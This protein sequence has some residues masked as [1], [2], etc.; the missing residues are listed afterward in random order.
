MAGFG[1]V[2][3]VRE[4]RRD[5]YPAGERPYYCLSKLGVAG[6]GM[7]ETLSEITVPGL[8]L[9][10][11]TKLL[12]ETRDSGAFTAFVMTSSHGHEMF[13][14]I[15]PVYVGGDVPGSVSARRES[16]TGWIIGLFDAEPILAAAVAREGGVAVSLERE[17]AAV[18]EYRVPTG[19]GA[20]FR[21]LSETMQT[22]SVA[23]FGSV[24]PA[25]AS[26]SGSPSRPTVAGR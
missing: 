4:R 19:A 18:P 13:E 8:D 26:P 12:G 24:G 11:L 9:C 17:H 25:T 2:E 21:T 10:Q 7:A 20:A 5:V 23:R 15:A 14:V 3:L 1:Y 22:A 16:A 6:P